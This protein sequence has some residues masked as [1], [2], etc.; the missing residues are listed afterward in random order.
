VAGRKTESPS[1]RP[2]VP[3]SRSIETLRRAAA[4][5]KGCDL[6]KD[7]T[8]R[9][10]FRASRGKRRIHQ[11]PRLSEIEACRPW[12][13]AEIAAVEPR[14]IVC[15]GATAARA[16]MGASFRITRSRGQVLEGTEGNTV[17]ATGHPSAVPRAHDDPEQSRAL[18]EQL[19]ADLRV[20]A[21]HV[22]RQPS[23]AGLAASVSD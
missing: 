18:F 22:R 11:T 16:L 21:E 7:A 17:I 12:T 1:A 4:K 9:P 20:A 2:F 6:Y 23:G 15:L 19:T 3:A 10:A 14:V 13:E 8:A 5:C